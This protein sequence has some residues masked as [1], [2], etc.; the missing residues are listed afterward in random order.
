MSLSIIDAPTLMSRLLVFIAIGIVIGTVW[1]WPSTDV[2]AVSTMIAFHPRVVHI[3]CIGGGLIRGGS[4]CPLRLCCLGP[5][6]SVVTVSPITRRDADGD[7]MIMMQ[8]RP[9]PQPVKLTA[10][11][12]I[13]RIIGIGISSVL[14]QDICLRTFC[15][16]VSRWLFQLTVAASHELF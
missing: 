4:P 6:R 2:S 9:G 10:S 3:I 12:S 8:V 5:Y 1:A 11:A 14:T 7:A 15:V 13:S 16:S